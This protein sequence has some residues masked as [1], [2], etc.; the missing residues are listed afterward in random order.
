MTFTKVRLLRRP[1]SPQKIVSCL[2]V[3]SQRPS[4]LGHLAKTLHLWL[5][6]SLLLL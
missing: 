1:L 5:V 6:G 3:S 4:T 2:Q